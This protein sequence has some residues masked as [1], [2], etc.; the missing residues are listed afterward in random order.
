MRIER[1]H[2]TLSQDSE[3]RRAYAEEDLIHRVA[4]RVYKLRLKLDM[5]QAELAD[6]LDT[7]QPAIARIEGGYENLTLR[8]VARLSYALDCRP[9]DLVDRETPVVLHED[10]NRDEE[11]EAEET[12]VSVTDTSPMSATRVLATVDDES[13]MWA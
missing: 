9:E 12:V 4:E 5:S 8:S 11:A 2:D 7:Q 13:L 3:Y 10:W 1:L 6:E